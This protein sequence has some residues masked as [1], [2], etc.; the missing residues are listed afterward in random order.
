MVSGLI[1]T[2]T[3]KIANEAFNKQACDWVKLWTRGVYSKG[4]GR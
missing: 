3:I 4:A 2:F 1:L